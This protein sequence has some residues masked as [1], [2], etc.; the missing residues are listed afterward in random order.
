MSDQCSVETS[1]ATN[2]GPSAHSTYTPL[3]NT[4]V[5]TGFSITAQHTAAIDSWGDNHLSSPDWLMWQHGCDPFPDGYLQCEL[6]DL[7]LY[8]ERR[9]TT[10]RALY[11]NFYS[12]CS[13]KPLAWVLVSFVARVWPWQ[14]L[15]MSLL[16]QWSQSTLPWQT[17]GLAHRDRKSVV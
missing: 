8:I 15:F 1:T 10:R 5:H 12:E 16:R 17:S 7:Y 4:T 11:R 9:R 14:P 13:C 6:M 2:S 3:L